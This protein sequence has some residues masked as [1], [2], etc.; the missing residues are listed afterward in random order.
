MRL[1][2]ECLSLCWSPTS[3]AALPYPHLPPHSLLGPVITLLQ[4]QSKMTVMIKIGI[5]STST[6]CVTL[7]V[8]DTQIEVNTLNIQLVETYV[9]LFSHY[10]VNSK[11]CQKVPS[12]V[13]EANCSPIV[14]YTISKCRGTNIIPCF[15][16]SLP[17]PTS[18]LSS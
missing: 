9:N 11:V 15:K 1:V 16:N 6:K 12:V 13:S 2:L 7:D 3:Q 4:L 5:S 8:E 17:T 18:H 10:W 14:L